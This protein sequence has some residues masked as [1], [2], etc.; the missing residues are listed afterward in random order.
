MLS[1]ELYCNITVT[2]DMKKLPK[3]I[4]TIMIII[5]I[6]KNST[7]MDHRTRKVMTMHKGLHPRDDND[8]MCQ[9][10]KEEED[11]TALKIA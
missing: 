7:K 1:L 2:A 8:Y 9:E 4:I 3:S 10:K 11:L 5:I 6:T